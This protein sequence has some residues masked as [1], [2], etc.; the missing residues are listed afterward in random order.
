VCLDFNTRVVVEENC[1]VGTAADPMPPGDFRFQAC[2]AQ[3]PDGTMLVGG[4]CFVASN[5]DN[6]LGLIRSVPV[7]GPGS[8]G[9]LWECGVINGSPVV[10]VQGSVSIEAKA[11]CLV[12]GQCQEPL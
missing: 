2:A 4:G 1:T 3:C 12:V 6:L 5:A 8:V 11:I 9:G 10:T 7:T